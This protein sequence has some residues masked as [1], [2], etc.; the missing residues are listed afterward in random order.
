MLTA[1]SAA[2]GPD[3]TVLEVGG[4]V[5]IAVIVLMAAFS[6]RL[7]I[8]APILLVVVG[9]VASYIPGLP[10]ID[11]PHEFVLDVLLPP[12]LY[13]AAIRLPF[14]DFRRNLGTIL[15]LSVVL[16][17]VTAFGTGFVLFAA[18]PD[19]NLAA[20]VALGAVL[21]P[22]DA[23]AATAVGRRLGLPPR[24]V[25]VL[26]GEGLVNDATALVLLG[27]A[28]ALVT[29]TKQPDLLLILQDFAFAVVVAVA[30]GF[31]VGVVTVPGAGTARGPGARDGDLD[32]GAVPGVRADA[33]RSTPPACSPSSSPG[34][35][36]GYA[37][38]GLVLGGHADQ[39][40]HQL[41][42]HPVPAGERG[43]PAR[44]GSRSARSSSRSCTRPR[45][46]PC[47]P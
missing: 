46:R 39:R 24:L 12:I 44:S 3:L 33:R 45:A 15:S 13:A 27:S 17:L 11:V 42:H 2:Q 22:P 43:L 16:V 37:N 34:S 21:S 41:E 30:I 47:C 14:V 9:V 25:V 6:R 28:A 4:V 1:T 36:P 20:G 10:R 40:P 26:E 5:A 19:L 8:A 18:L 29:E 35:T 38:P 23:V 31:V 7:G 32:R